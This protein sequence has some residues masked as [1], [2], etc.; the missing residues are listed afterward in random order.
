M[1][2][3]QLSV[4]RVF[5]KLVLIC[6][7]FKLISAQQNDDS[8]GGDSDF[9]KVYMDQQVSGFNS[10]NITSGPVILVDKR[11]VYI[12]DFRY[13]GPHG[14]GLQF[15]VGEGI[16]PYNDTEQYPVM[17]H[18]DFTEYSSNF[19]LTLPEEHGLDSINYLQL[20]YQDQPLDYVLF[21]QADRKLLKNHDPSNME[22]SLY[23]IPK[24]CKADEYYDVEQR[25]ASAST[26]LDFNIKIFESNE[27]G[28]DPD[29]ILNSSDYRIIP[30]YRKLKCA[31]QEVVM[32]I[33]STELHGIIYNK[34]LIV[35]GQDIYNHRE[36]CVDGLNSSQSID[37]LVLVCMQTLES[38]KELNFYLPALI[39]ST[40]CFALSTAAYGV[41]LRRKDIHKRCFIMFSSSMCLAFVCLIVMQVQNS[42]KT[43]NAIGFVFLLTV[44]LSFLW[45]LILCLEL[46]YQVIRPIEDKRYNPRWYWYCG[47]SFGLSFLTFLISLLTGEQWIPDVPNSFI[48]P[49][50][51]IS[52]MCEFQTTLPRAFI[53]FTPIIVSIVG[54]SISLIALQPCINRNEKDK[55]INSHF[56][57]I[58]HS[59]NY[60]FLYRTYIMIII[61]AC[62]WLLGIFFYSTQLD[63]TKTQLALDVI[64]ASLGIVTFVG[65]VG[66]KYTRAEI[67]DKC[68]KKKFTEKDL[69]LNGYSTPTSTPETQ[70][71]NHEDFPLMHQR[72]YG[73]LTTFQSSRPGPTG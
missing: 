38:S 43:C 28:L 59:N 36:F 20:R 68:H 33:P 12:T 18:K 13:F 44:S 51:N 35:Q 52:N 55:L 30:Y 57:W 6:V 17:T 29:V 72:N 42:I 73:N 63:N 54:S 48:M 64:K 66:N 31:P 34:T 61:V 67:S 41:I 60:K 21:G 53:V 9:P 37:P 70:L 56:D 7:C 39:L 71:D 10:T 3:S 69:E 4:M 32:V 47:I 58:S 1:S 2:E 16:S 25:C 46:L 22:D 62:F 27:T 49:Y 40:L 5:L 11:I 45:L 15:W 50:G 14:D 26:I 19:Y 23:R 65:F 24:C 8:D